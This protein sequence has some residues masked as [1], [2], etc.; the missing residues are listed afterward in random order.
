MT[1][2][3]DTSAVVQIDMGPRD[4]AGAHR[5]VPLIEITRHLR[6]RYGVP[7]RDPGV[8]QQVTEVRALRQQR[9]RQIEHFDTD[10]AIEPAHAHPAIEKND[11][12]VN[13]IQRPGKAF[14]NVMNRFGEEESR[15]VS[16]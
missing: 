7:R 10:E 2:E 11:A 12:N 13:L 8:V 1:G 9:R 14:Q 6:P 5:G 15:H 16:V 4:G 3:Q